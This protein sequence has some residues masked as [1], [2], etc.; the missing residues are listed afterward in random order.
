MPRNTR[1]TDPE[2]RNTS[3]SP[4]AVRDGFPLWLLATEVGNQIWY[5]GLA[6]AAGLV[7]LAI[8]VVFS[9]KMYY[10]AQ[11]PV[12]ECQDARYAQEAPQ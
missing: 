10:D 11:Q 7:S 8:A 6:I 5:A 4:E 3:L 2:K 1:N 12:L 9:V